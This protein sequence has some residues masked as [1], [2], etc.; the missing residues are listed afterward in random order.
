MM[1]EATVTTRA[2]NLILF[3]EDCNIH[4]ESSPKPNTGKHFWWFVCVPYVH[5]KVLTH[6][7]MQ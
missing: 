4:G 3:G 7:H 2:A 6:T 5:L 1:F